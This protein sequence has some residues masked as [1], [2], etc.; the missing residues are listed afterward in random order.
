MQKSRTP[1]LAASCF[2]GST[3]R[4]PH[5]SRVVRDDVDGIA[6]RHSKPVFW[7]MRA[8]SL[9]TGVF[10]RRSE[11]SGCREKLPPD[12]LRSAAALPETPKRDTPP[13]FLLRLSSA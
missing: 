9:P 2:G 1:Q 4:R 3:S 6:G 10:R 13:L 8:P 5:Q 7:V 11:K 12:N